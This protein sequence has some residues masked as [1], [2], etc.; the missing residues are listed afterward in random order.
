M[1]TITRNFI[2]CLL[3]LLF[4]INECI[5]GQEKDNIQLLL[6]TALKNALNENDKNPS[7]NTDQGIYLKLNGELQQKLVQRST[8]IQRL[9]KHITELRMAIDKV[10]E[11]PLTTLQPETIT[12][13]D[14]KNQLDKD[15]GVLNNALSRI[16]WD[17]EAKAQ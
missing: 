4:G 5:S 3:T 8:A 16:N 11:K 2:I 10:D 14:I 1:N 17:Q 15:L 12:Q 6:K 9:K 13:N 7:G